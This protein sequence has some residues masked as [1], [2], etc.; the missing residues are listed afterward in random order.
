MKAYVLNK[1]GQLDYMERPL[2]EPK[3]GEVL[4][5][6]GAVGIC[7]SD[8]PRIFETGTYHFPTIPGHEFSG[9]VVD[10]YDVSGRR[11]I[12]KRVGVFPLIPC[13]RCSSCINRQY[14]MCS[15][16]DYLG[17]RSDG[18]FAEY[19]RVPVWNLLELP[20]GVSMEA[21]AMLEPASVALHALRRL[22]LRKDDTVVIFG[23]GTIGC[24][25]AQWLH[26]LHIEKVLAV[27]HRQEPGILMHK[28]ASQDYLYRME[29]EGNVR[30]WI[31]EI[32]GGQGVDIAIDCAGSL[33]T[34]ANCL[35]SVR[36][37]GQVL[38]VGNPQGEMALSK[39]S[40][41]KIL[42]KQLR[43]TGTWNSSFVHQAWD[44]WH[45]AV[46]HMEAKS[47]QPEWLITHTLDFG[48]LSKGLR[49]MRGHV[50][51]YNKIMILENRVYGEQDA[52]I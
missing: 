22:E 40:Y 14:E 39:E 8:I 32:T 47:L 2:P 26:A 23:L 25:V 52:E 6:V 42:R 28:T 51:Y 36:P 21:G 11:W 16:Y 37:G 48:D 27:G 33:I 17:S 46:R 34:V 12:G 9:T 19:V 45:E 29:E 5:K 44:D 1:I 7:G 50:E 20:A 49:I 4:V 35:E 41:W 31:C 3:E 15:S 30:E 43:L 24:L 18:G 13:G 10:A 38:L